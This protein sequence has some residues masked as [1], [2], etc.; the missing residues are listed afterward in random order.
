MLLRRQFA[1]AGSDPRARTYEILSRNHTAG[2]HLHAAA[3]WRLSFSLR[4]P[5]PD[6]PR[7]R[8]PLGYR[9]GSLR[10]IRPSDG[11]DGNGGKTLARDDSAATHDAEPER[12]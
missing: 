10:A 9:R 4:R 11:A 8:A 12:S 3:R 6:A 5:L 7:N 1:S 2:Q